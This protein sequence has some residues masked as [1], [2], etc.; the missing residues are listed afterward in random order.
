MLSVI[1]LINSK[2][3]LGIKDKILPLLKSSIRI[4]THAVPEENLE[5]GISKIGGSPDLPKDFDWPEIENDK[6][7]LSFLAQFNLS[8]LAQYDEEKALPSSGMLYI[9]FDTIR[10]IIHGYDEDY[11]EVSKIMYLDVEPEELF[12]AQPPKQLVDIRNDLWDAGTF[13]SCAVTFTKEKVLPNLD[14]LY[15]RELGLTK[16][17]DKLYVQLLQEISKIYNK[18]EDLMLRL[19]IHVTHRL[20]GYSDGN[21]GNF[22]EFDC[23]L[24]LEGTLWREILKG[25]YV[26]LDESNKLRIKEKSKNWRLIFQIDSDHRAQTS[27]GDV[28]RIYFWIQD[29]K[30]QG[31]DFSITYGF[32]QG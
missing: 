16:T 3:F 17:E 18:K 30:L 10:E 28:G 32:Y 8:K 14:S 23:Q 22:M 5:I 20:L 29:D 19:P 1:E 9:F 12:R 31:R 24:L 26:N 7:S 13:R 4:R 6:L 15:I 21:N 2:E 25:A 11:N 27:W